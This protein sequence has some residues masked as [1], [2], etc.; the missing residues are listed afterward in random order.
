MLK[1]IAVLAPALLLAALGVLVAPPASAATVPAAPT[2]LTGAY[3]GGGTAAL[4]WTDNAVDEAGYELEL[5]VALTGPCTTFVQAVRLPAGT[6]TFTDPGMST[7]TYYRVRAVNTAGA[8]AY[9]N[10]AA[11][12]VGFSTGENPTAVLASTATSGT[13]PLTVSFDGAASTGF[14]GQAITSWT[15]TFGDGTTANGAQASHTFTAAGTY[16]V[17]L[18]V[19]S[20]FGV[21]RA[22]VPVYVEQKT[23]VAPSDLAATA[24][25]RSRVALAWTNPVSTTTSIVVQRCKGAGCTTFTNLRTLPATATTYADTTVSSRSTYTYRLRV[26]DGT[27]ATALSN[28]ATATTPR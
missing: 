26:T 17:V 21:D 24:T 18:A 25:S 12:G 15:W 7:T 6:T 5:C 9:S 10:V 11:V 13:A 2:G 1:K 20:G 3:T 22:W 23:L 28:T 14:A 16:L 19:S 27:P 8:S 4:A